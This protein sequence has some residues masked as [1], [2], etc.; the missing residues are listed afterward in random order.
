MLLPVDSDMALRNH[1]K[2][3]KIYMNNKILSIHYLRGIAALV[4]V[5][6]HFRGLLNGY[7][8]QKDIGNILFGS[9]A[10]GVDLFFMIS[11]FII[12]LS[13]EK[14]MTPFIF[15]IRRFFRIYPAFI[16]VFI[17]AALTIYSDIDKPQLIKSMFF[18]HNDYSK[19]SP[20]F[21]FNILGP[22]WTLTYEFYFYGLFMLAMSFSHK[23]RVAISA[24]M[25]II[26][27]LALQLYYNGNISLA[28]SASARVHESFYLHGFI[29]FCSS[30]ILVEF[31]IGM[32]S[33]TLFKKLK[34]IEYNANQ[35]LYY[36]PVGIFLVF[37]FSQANNRFGLDGFGMWS[38]FLFLGCM[39]KELSKGFK[40]N[41]KLSFLGDISYSL[42]ITH[43]VVIALL[44]HYSPMYWEYTGGIS[45]FIYATIVSLSVAYFTYTFIEKPFIRIGKSI[46]TRLRR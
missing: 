15:F 23:Y 46:E 20:A 21:G 31:V 41:N 40:E 3:P 6:F 36:F 34:E 14:K 27:I 45:K 19:E 28:G 11:G 38:L 10:F 30:P 5:F 18:V 13:T 44:N 42:Y 4:V 1:F 2:G 25:L 29:R 22:A 17:V 8:S 37:Y 9:G 26:P 33:F 16:F 43:Y 12:A 35:F 7:Y 24:C 39:S 32:M